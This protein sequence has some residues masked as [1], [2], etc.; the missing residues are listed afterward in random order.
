M[1]AGAVAVFIGETM[2]PP[3]SPLLPFKDY[4]VW[5]QFNGPHDVVPLPARLEEITRQP[6]STK[7]TTEWDR[8]Q[9]NSIWVYEHYF[10][11]DVRAVAGLL[12]VLGRRIRGRA[13]PA[14]LEDGHF[15]T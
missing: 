10:A 8:L 9:R 11:T 14:V 5:V 13:E 12:E 6:G 1:S 2:E 3:F 7:G 15:K 4:A